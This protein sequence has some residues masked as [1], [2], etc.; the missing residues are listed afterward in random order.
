MKIVEA[1]ASALLNESLVGCTH[2]L[3]DSSGI[4]LEGRLV[5]AAGRSGYRRLVG[6]S[7]VLVVGWR[8]SAGV[9]L[10]FPPGRLNPY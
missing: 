9:T 7:V 4:H 1:V 10:P 5:S 6:R 3:R 2:R 8:G